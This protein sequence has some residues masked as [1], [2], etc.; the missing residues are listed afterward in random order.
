MIL[1]N[2]RPIHLASLLAITLV[3]SSCA[4]NQASNPN[5]QAGTGSNG[6]NGNASSL[7]GNVTIDGS[8]TVFPISEVVAEEFRKT[9]SGVQVAVGESGTG[10]GFKKFCAGE[11]SLTG[12]SRPIKPEEIEACKTGNIEYIEIPIAYDALTVAAN[13][14]NEAAK[15]MK[16]ADLKKVWEPAA[17]GKIT[18]WNQINPSFPDLKLS[19]YGP[20][21]DS[22]TFDYFTKEIVGKEKDSRSD[23]TASEDDN[24]LVQGIAGDRGGLGYFGY[25]YYEANKEQLKAV[26]IDSGKGCVAPSAETVLAGT[27]TPLSRPIF[28]YASKKDLERPEVKAFTDFMLAGN[29]KKLIS[30]VGYVPLPD[31]LST[32]VQKRYESGQ[33]GSL[34][35]GAPKG[36]TLKDLLA[37]AK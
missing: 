22:G 10:G 28:V 24:T 23:Y 27:Y 7:S 36:S 19:L 31:E 26:E 16:V 32:A 1:Q 2:L 12:A 33:V 30:E 25:A 13:P 34:Y 29:S 11:I 4:G 20:G 14:Q 9:N 8:S 6:S 5:G 15:C 3:T 21:T 17:Q 35:Q 37:K 18:N